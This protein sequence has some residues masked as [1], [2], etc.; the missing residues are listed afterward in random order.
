MENRDQRVALEA[1]FTDQ[2]EVNATDLLSILKP[3]VKI[4]R[5]TNKI[6]FLEEAHQESVKIKLLLYLLGHKVLYILGKMDVEEVAPTEIIRDTRMKRGTVL[7]TLRSLD[8][9][10][11]AM[12]AGGKYFVGNHQIPKI[13]G[14]VAK[15]ERKG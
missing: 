8:K 15:R 12:S 6:F 5:E 7:P 2:D 13:K 11:L 4:Q 9:E 1:L 3:F 10:G 14:L